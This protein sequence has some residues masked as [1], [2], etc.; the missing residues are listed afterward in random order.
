[1]GKEQINPPKG[2]YKHEKI[3]ICNTKELVEIFLAQLKLLTEIPETKEIECPHKP[4][5]TARDINGFNQRELFEHIKSKN[6]YTA[7]LKLAN[8]IQNASM[9]EEGKLLIHRTSKIILKKKKDFV[10]SWKDVRGISIMPAIYMI[11]DKLSNKYLKEKLHPLIYTQQHGARKGMS[12]ATA[13]MNI[14]YPLKKENFNIV[15]S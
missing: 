2:L 12:T 14:I 6:I 10:N 15:Y 9:S 3:K 4:K 5:S 7:A 11:I 1:M 8:I 13:K